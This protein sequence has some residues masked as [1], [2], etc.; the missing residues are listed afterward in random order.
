MLGSA[1]A[2]LTIIFACLKAAGVIAWSWWSVFLPIIV[3][4]IVVLLFIIS[5]LVFEAHE[6][7]EMD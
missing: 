3:W 7:C 1:A 5:A 2:I 4:L 6:H